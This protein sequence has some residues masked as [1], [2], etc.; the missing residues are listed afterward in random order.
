MDEVWKDVHVRHDC[1]NYEVSN[2]GKVRNKVKQRLLKGWVNPNGY[3]II[4]FKNNEG[5]RRRV[6]LHVLLAEAFHPNVEKKP[7]VDHTNRQRNDNRLEN[8][9]WATLKENSNNCDKTRRGPKRGVTQ[10]TRSGELVNTFSSIEEAG[11]QMNLYPGN[12][13]KMCAGKSKSKTCGGYI[14]KYLE[15]SCSSETW[16]PLVANGR[17][18]EVSDHGHVRFLR[19]G[20]LYTTK[21]HLDHTYYRVTIRGDD[22]DEKLPVHRLVMK[23][24]SP[25]EDETDMVVDHLDGDKTNN[26]LTNLEWVTNEE[27]TKRGCGRKVQ[28]RDEN[29]NVKI[30][31]TIKD[32]ANDCKVARHI[33]TTKFLDKDSQYTSM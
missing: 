18:I 3:T 8:L 33:F 6:G 1:S 7:I 16:R 10:W 29:G 25:I 23:A 22:G 20:S 24:F 5:E 9:A 13:S 12:I 4:E 30:F 11:K 31:S 15:V 14:W 19:R 27:N 2:T 17:N 28:K 32:A 26:K 21:G